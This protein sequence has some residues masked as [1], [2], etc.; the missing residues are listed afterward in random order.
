M[1]HDAEPKEGDPRTQSGPDRERPASDAVTTI[2]DEWRLFGGPTPRHIGGIRREAALNVG[3]AALISL[4]ST[5]LLFGGIAPFSGL[6][7]WVVVAWAIFLGSYALL[8]AQSDDRPAVVDSVVTVGLWSAGLLVL[9]ILADVVIYTFWRGGPSLIHLNFFQQDLSKT[10]P[11]A[12]LSSGG[13]THAVAGTL[14]TIGIALVVTVPLGLLCAVYLSES[15]SRVSR[16]V[17]MI[18][19]AMTALPDIIAGLFIFATWILILKFGFSGL[20]AALA[21]SVAMLPIIIRTADV[22]LRL[23]PGNLREASAALGAPQWR[24]V[25]HV[26]L[27]TAKSGLA[28]AV[29]LGAARGI[30]ETAPVLLTAGYTLFFN[31]NPTNGPMVTLPLLAFKLVGSGEPNMVTRGYG[32]ASLLFIMVIVIFAFAR[33]IGGRGAGQHSRGKIRRL[34]ARSARDLARISRR[35][36]I[37]REF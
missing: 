27:P 7:A 18:V 23:V 17:R 12:P 16:L 13:V 21:L 20:A 15:R 8:V 11:R 30:G 14:W 1:I 4:C 9:S 35:S 10:G 6:V 28:T 3:G 25:M 33:F 29:I 5:A 37:E 32:A 24:T 19:E 34:N 31:S 2:S 22:V 36:L 26:V